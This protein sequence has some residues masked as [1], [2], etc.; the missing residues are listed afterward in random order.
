MK[1]NIINDKKIKKWH[2]AIILIFA[3]FLTV[4]TSVSA[5]DTGRKDQIRS[6]GIIDYANKTVVIDSKDLTYLAEEI[7]DLE[8][9]YKINM[10]SALSE[11]GTYFKT[12]GSAVHNR[13]EETIIPDNAASLTFI[14]LYEGILGSQS[15]THLEGVQAKNKDGELLYYESLE[16]AENRDL[17]RT[18]KT[19]NDIPVY[20]R[21]I[22][23]RNLSA[24]TAAWV[25]GTLIIGNGADNEA[26]YTKG[27]TDGVASIGDSVSVEYTY[28]QHTDACYEEQTL[29]CYT[30]IIFGSTYN[31]HCVGCQKEMP[32]DATVKFKK[33]VKKHSSCGAADYES[34]YCTNHQNP[35]SGSSHEYQTTVCICGKTEKTVE[36]AHIIFN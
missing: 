22:E 31:K 12:D 23:E 27:Y 16:D 21:P 19:P 14:S 9:S 10:A 30:S 25:N 29:T 4:K 33:Y 36:S 28:H 6:K 26:F 20:I 24:G 5:V 13:T 17:T 1:K 35:P 15:V 8:S 3:G 34:A 32:D 11:I 7:D 2:V 18:T